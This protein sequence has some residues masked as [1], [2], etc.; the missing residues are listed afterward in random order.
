MN[1]HDPLLSIVISNYN[2]ERFVG[3]T[4]ESALDLDWPNKEIIVVDDGSTDGS[5]SI[6][7]GF[8]DKGIVALQQ[9]NARQL[10]AQ[11]LGYSHCHGDLVIFL[12][13]DDL[14]ATDLMQHVRPLLRDGISKIQVRMAVIDSEGNFTGTSY[15]QLS[16]AMSPLAIRNW[17][18][19]TFEYPTPPGSGNIYTRRFLETLFPIE[20]LFDRSLDPYVLS[21]A[22][23]A[24]DVI[25]INKPLV[26]YRVHGSNQAAMADLN[27]DKFATEVSRTLARYEFSKQYCQKN[28]YRVPSSPLGKS[29]QFLLLRAASFRLSPARHPIEGDSGVKIAYHAIKTFFQPHYY[30]RKASFALCLWAVAIALSPAHLARRLAQWRFAPTTRPALLQ[31]L[32]GAT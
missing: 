14:L 16:D 17:A 21:T 32:I 10:R 25:T 6:I 8:S 22:P 12:D 23:H 4:I 28:G 5:W 7:Q 30:S 27:V 31:K 9:E 24:G 3:K 1:I 13:S 18:E 19:Q 26:Y 11:I 20:D 29:V 15:P 2:Y